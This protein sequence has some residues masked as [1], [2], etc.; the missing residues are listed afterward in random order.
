MLDCR[1][2]LTLA[3]PCAGSEG[4]G[5]GNGSGSD[6]TGNCQGSGNGSRVGSRP[7]ASHLPHAGSMSLPWGDSPPVPLESSS[8]QHM[9][10]SQPLCAQMHSHHGPKPWDTAPKPIYQ[11]STTPF[12]AAS[13]AFMRGHFFGQEDMHQVHASA[14]HVAAAAAAAAAMARRGPAASQ[15]LHIDPL[16]RASSLLH[17]QVRPDLSGMYGFDHV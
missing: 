16:Q 14:F 3:S 5:E 12:Q 7:P 17:Q 9:A 15:A 11:M 6:G 8:S 1:S 4:N 10:A 13:R 2:L